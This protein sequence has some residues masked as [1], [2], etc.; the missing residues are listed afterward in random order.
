MPRIE[1]HIWSIVSVRWE[2]YLISHIVDM[3][4]DL[5]LAVEDMKKMILKEKDFGPKLYI[6]K[7]VI[8]S[9]E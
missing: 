5:E 1:K 4:D 7:Q 2:P 6:E 3:Y 8:K 9:K